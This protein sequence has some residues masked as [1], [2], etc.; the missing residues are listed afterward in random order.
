M[1]RGF[2]TV[3][4]ILLISTSGCASMLVPQS[5]GMVPGAMVHPEE[6]SES[7]S[8]GEVRL[9]VVPP[10]ERNERGSAIASAPQTVAPDLMDT[11]EVLPLPAISAA[12]VAAADPRTPATLV[13]VYY[14]TNRP[15]RDEAVGNHYGTCDV[16]IP[17]R[18]QFGELER[19]SLWRLEF[20]ESAARHVMLK[21]VTP[22]AGD[23]CLGQL[24]S[25]LAGTSSPEIFV[26]IHGYNVTFQEAAMR[27][28][29]MAFDLKFGGVPLFY[30]W[31]S[32][33]DITGY[34]S[35]LQHA[36]GS[37]A[38]LAEFLT[39]V[40]QESGAS[41]IHLVAHSMGNRALVGALTRISAT[42]QASQF[43]QV[44][45]AAPDLDAGQFAT[46]IAPR[47]RPVVQRAT[48][49][50]SG[51]DLALWASRLW[52]RTVRLGQPGRYLNEISEYDWIDVIDA[53]SIGFDWF[54]LGHSAYG[55]ELLVDLHRVLAGRPAGIPSELP[56]TQVWTVAR[57]SG[58]R[59][60]GPVPAPNHRPIYQLRPARWP[61]APVDR[62]R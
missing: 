20:R 17:A 59:P 48:I 6:L 50:S 31:P 58:A 27:T 45:F 28:A 42:Q 35:D 39:R 24:R 55:S 41:Q 46:E 30:S 52:N 38:P 12:Q 26:F 11:E 8:R 13:R 32:R 4:L 29:Q 56:G 53:T 62:W 19:P 22:L 43:S 25:D 60:S 5:W 2:S 37:A 1:F 14:G 10:E 9:A 16:S 57:P 18:H 7:P 34:G 3:I 51:S 47:I 36:D 40:S 61:L 15:V 44:V 33:G 54:E 21:S 23:A 49:Y